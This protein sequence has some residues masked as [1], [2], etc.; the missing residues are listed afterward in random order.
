MVQVSNGRTQ[1]NA[2]PPA[3]STV[4][5]PSGPSGGRDGPAPRSRYT[6]PSGKAT[7]ICV[8][9]LSQFAATAS[10]PI[11]GSPMW[12]RSSTVQKLTESR[13]SGL[14]GRWANTYSRD[15]SIPPVRSIDMSFLSLVDGAGGP[16][17]CVLDVAGE[18]GPN[19][20]DVDAE[21]DGV[22]VRA[23]FAL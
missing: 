7:L 20:V 2:N 3:P 17:V 9:W 19:R 8:S 12:P 21:L 4:G 13:I 22:G 10:T 18:A 6:R 16:T 1:R 11:R 23:G 5:M 14:S 15:R